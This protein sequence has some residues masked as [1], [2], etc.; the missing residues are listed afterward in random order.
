VKIYIFV[1]EEKTKGFKWGFQCSYQMNT[2][3]W[4]MNFEHEQWAC[5]LDFDEQ[6]RIFMNILGMYTNII[7]LFT[8]HIFPIKPMEHSIHKNNFLRTYFGVK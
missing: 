2:C 4:A 7:C 1:R 5:E 6:Q 8:S 3:A